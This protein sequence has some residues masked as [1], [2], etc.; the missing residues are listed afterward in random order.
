MVIYCILLALFRMGLFGAAQ[1]WGGGDPTPFL[2]ICNT[3][4]YDQVLTQLYS[5]TLP[6]EDPKNT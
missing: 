5:Y 2:K 3:S 6:K 4:Y 1:G